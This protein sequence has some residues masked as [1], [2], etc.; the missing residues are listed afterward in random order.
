MDIESL[1]NPISEKDVCGE[2]LCY[3]NVYDELKELR[4]ED[5]LRLSQGI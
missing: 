4:R 1:L 2:N 5:D 3:D